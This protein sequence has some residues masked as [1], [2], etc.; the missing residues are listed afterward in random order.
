MIAV[1]LSPFFGGAFLLSVPGGLAG[2]WLA[3]RLDG[4]GV[5]L[6]A[7][8]GGGLLLARVAMA[9]GGM[10]W[11]W[12]AER[13]E[14]R[15]LSH[16]K[17]VALIRSG[18]IRGFSKEGHSVKLVFT[19]GALKTRS[20]HPLAKADVSG[21]ASYVAAAKEVRYRHGLID[22]FDNSGPDDP[23]SPVNRDGPSMR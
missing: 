15:V 4:L 14:S 10:Y 18:A 11:S 17:T 3:T 22:Y 21:Y 6:V 5:R 12:R 2:I 7:G 8:L 9:A 13:K 20:R 23:S 16:A 19:A 1:A